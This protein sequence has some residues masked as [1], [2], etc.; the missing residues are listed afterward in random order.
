[1]N[2]G[3]KVLIAFHLGYQLSTSETEVIDSG[4]INVFNNLATTEEAELNNLIA[5]CVRGYS[6]LSQ[7][8]NVR[9]DEKV[10][11]TRIFQHCLNNQ[12]KFGE[13]ERLYWF[14]LTRI[15]EILRVPI[16]S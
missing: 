5:A 15:S 8:L 7:S 13:N 4:M 6:N 12:K 3:N 2:S 9:G 14:S 1:M 16:K 11:R 10:V